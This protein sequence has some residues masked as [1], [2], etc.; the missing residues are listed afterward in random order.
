MKQNDTCKNLDPRDQH[1][2]GPNR[3][4]T[5][6]QKET[7]KYVWMWEESYDKFTK[8]DVFVSDKI[9][10]SFIGQPLYFEFGESKYVIERHA[11]DAGIQ[12]NME[13]QNV[14]RIQRRTSFIF[15]FFVF[16]F[17]Y[18]LCASFCVTCCYQSQK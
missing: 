10:D 15:I 1:N 7:E 6:E 2:N 5:D 14:R 16:T 4:N 12:T 17:F 18:S 8:Y 11:I 3:K 13:T 9:E